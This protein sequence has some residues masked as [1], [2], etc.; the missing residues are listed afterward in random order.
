MG[1]FL[2]H[3]ATPVVQMLAAGMGEMI[4]QPFCNKFN[5]HDKRYDSKR[6]KTKHELNPK[7]GIHKDVQPQSYLNN[8]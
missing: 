5:Q 1:N 7:T 8:L 2:Y 3:E 6:R 4:I